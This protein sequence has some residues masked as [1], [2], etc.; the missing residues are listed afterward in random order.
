MSVDFEQQWAVALKKAQTQTKQQETVPLSI[1]KKQTKEEFNYYRRRLLEACKNKNQIDAEK[2]LKLLL[3]SRAELVGLNLERQ[4]EKTG[5]YTEADFKKEVEKYTADC[6]K[7]INITE[8]L[9]KAY[10]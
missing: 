9:F 5:D 8:K 7:I 2:Y 1:Q 6:A 3:K 4:K 10:A